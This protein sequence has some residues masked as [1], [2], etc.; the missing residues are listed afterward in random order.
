M[1]NVSGL[2]KNAA[3]NTFTFKDKNWDE[4]EKIVRR[5]SLA[6]IRCIIEIG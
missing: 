2:V 1:Y 6:E 4:F 3:G 5:E